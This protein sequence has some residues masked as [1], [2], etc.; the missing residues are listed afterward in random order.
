MSIITNKSFAVPCVGI[1]PITK[2]QF[3]IE[4]AHMIWDA[5]A[6]TML[7]R[8]RGHFHIVGLSNPLYKI[9]KESPLRLQGLVASV[10][11][12]VE[13]RFI[14]FENIKHFQVVEDE[15]IAKMEMTVTFQILESNL[16]YLEDIIEYKDQNLL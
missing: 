10:M 7:S 13:K 6:E 11:F 8:A 12:G 3:T 14:K 1:D 5:D 4:S 15:L 2:G 9:A 16:E